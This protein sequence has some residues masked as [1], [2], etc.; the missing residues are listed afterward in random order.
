MFK[1]NPLLP[2]TMVPMAIIIVLMT[3]LLTNTGLLVYEISCHHKLLMH[4]FVI[5]ISKYHVRKANTYFV[6]V[7]L[8]YDPPTYF[9]PIR[10]QVLLGPSQFKKGKIAVTTEVP[11]QLGMIG[12]AALDSVYNIC[13]EP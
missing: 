3:S 5:K 7:L 11:A 1:N 13:W 10:V 4:S 8:R 2:I 9:G 6:K 12:P